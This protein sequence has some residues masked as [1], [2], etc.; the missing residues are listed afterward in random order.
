MTQRVWD[1]D[2]ITPEAGR[3]AVALITRRWRPED[4]S[5]LPRTDDRYE[6]LRGKLLVTKA[7]SEE[8][9]SWCA[10]AHDALRAAAP[11]GWRVHWSLGIAIDDD[12][13]IPDLLVLSPE[14][15]GAHRAYNLV[16]PALVVEVESDGTK[17]V[18]RT[19]KHE[20][21][22]FAGIRAYWRIERTGVLH[23]YRL[24]GSEYTE[25]RVLRPGESATLDWPFPVTVSMP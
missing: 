1:F 12:R 20:A 19:G 14:A 21:Y 16:T 18:D 25:E 23:V 22:A 24:Q 9:Q 13:L 8:H 6:I 17:G 4:L 15:P 5:A 11:H 2:R 3:E 7:A 10:W